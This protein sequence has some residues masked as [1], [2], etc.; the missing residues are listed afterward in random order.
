MRN[1]DTGCD[2]CGN[3]IWWNGG[4]DSGKVGAHGWCG[5]YLTT[6][7]TGLNGSYGIFT[8]NET[9]GSWDNIYASGFNDSGMYIGACQECNARVTNAVM[10]NNS[11]GYSGS[12]SGGK[13]VIEYSLFRHN[14]A[15][16]APNSENPG[17]GPPPQDGE[18]GRPNIENPDPT[19]IITS[20]NITRCTVIRNNLILENNNLTV[21]ANASTA[22]APWGAGV[23]LA[24]RLRRSGRRERDRRQP[25]ERGD[26][27]RVSEPLHPRKWV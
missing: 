26:R 3:E 8:G 23:I 11:L 6:Y 21:P 12:N 9:E 7:D 25:H 2:H 14:S 22:A 17:D 20:T 15:G 27:L 1:F 19:P 16:I 5:R 13:L 10:E 18:C 4:A 24:G